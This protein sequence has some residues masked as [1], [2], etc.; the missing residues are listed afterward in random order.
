GEY[1]VFEIGASIGVV[2]I[3]TGSGSIV[4]V[5]AA[6]DSACY[7]AKDHGRNRIHV[8][9]PDDAALTQRQ[10]EMQ[11]V[12][13]LRQGLESGAFDLYCQPIVPVDPARV[14]PGRFFEILV[15]IQDREFISPGVFLPA[16]ERYHLM[17][18][19]DRWVIHTALA[20]LRE[21]Y[22]NDPET[23]PARFTINLSGQSLGD[24]A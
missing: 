3:T 12:Q 16:A 7:V 15:R 5:L 14:A 18:A 8:Y 24:D 23:V 21:Y 10:G 9:Q 1:S 4:D 2:P 22:A 13:R 20:L 19:I 11:W 17:P 6:A